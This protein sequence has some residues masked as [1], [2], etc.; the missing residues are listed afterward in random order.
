[1]DAINHEAT[2][3]LDQAHLNVLIELDTALPTTFLRGSGNISFKAIKRS[4]MDSS[5]KFG[6]IAGGGVSML[7]L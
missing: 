4:N 3:D 2:L 5:S 1:M 6:S 7:M